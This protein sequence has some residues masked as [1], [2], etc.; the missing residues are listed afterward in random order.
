ML[1]HPAIVLLGL[2]A[3]FIDGQNLRDGAGRLLKRK[4]FFE[5]KARPVVGPDVGPKTPKD[6]EDLTSESCAKLAVEQSKAETCENVAVQS[7]GGRTID[8]SA[9]NAVTNPQFAS[10]VPRWR[11]FFVVVVFLHLITFKPKSICQPL[12]IHRFSYI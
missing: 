7:A 3:Q 2:S 12:H 5:D 9:I 1:L 8:I 4:N 10:P 6:S 11:S